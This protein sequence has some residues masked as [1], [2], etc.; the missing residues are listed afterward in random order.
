MNENMQPPVPSGAQ[1][2]QPG[3]P[4]PPVQPGIPPQQT[5]PVPG[6]GT[7]PGFPVQTPSG[8]LT[9]RGLMAIIG[10][11]GAALILAIVGIFAIAM[12]QAVPNFVAN[13]GPSTGGA[14]GAAISTVGNLYGA[15]NGA[16]MDQDRETFFSHVSG[17]AVAPLTLWWDNMDRVGWTTGGISVSEF[18]D[19]TLVPSAQEPVE[20]ST[21]FGAAM[22]FSAFSPRGSGSFDAGKHFIQGEYYVAT[23]GVDDGLKITGWA[24]TERKAAWDLGELY[25]AR[26]EYSMVAGRPEE[27]ALIDSTVA[28]ADEA[29][30]WVLNDFA[31]AGRELPLDGFNIFVTAD[32]D[33]FSGW[34]VG[35]AV[36]GWL[37]D[38]AGFA[39]PMTRP[40]SGGDGLDPL[41]AT[42]DS[43]STSVVTIGPKALDGL[44]EVLAHEFVHVV[45][46]TE[47][48]S[49]WL[50][51]P[52]ATIEGWARYQQK[53]FSNG[54][55]F[56]GS[57]NALSYCASNFLSEGASVP[58]DEQLLG[59][60]A[61]CYYELAASAYAYAA[62]SGY[63]VFKLARLAKL[64]GQ[65]PIAASPDMGQDPVLSPAGWV[66][67]VRANY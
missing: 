37:I 45:H 63:D 20:V 22:G 30:A 47:I 26:G 44:A 46:Y 59:A 7:A 42:G 10:G 55:T 40:M 41:L 34:F 61:G 2:L 64:N 8:G 13:G 5:P 17:D 28:V 39:I 18:M 4:V 27:K 62:D 32:Q 56:P 49:S 48:S 50:S 23:I 58:T 65:D 52:R 54:G 67:W 21:I 14:S 38:V 51:P 11:S 53:R 1:P 25:V 60:D 29:A 31:Q 57:D 36:S 66:A 33:V 35:S 12:P 6:A 3:A 15:L 24:L 9:S 16:L 43:T 19:A